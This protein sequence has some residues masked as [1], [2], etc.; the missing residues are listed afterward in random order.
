V[1]TAYNISSVLETH[2]S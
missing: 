1:K 2:C